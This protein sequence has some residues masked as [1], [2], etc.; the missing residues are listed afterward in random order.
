M[1]YILFLIISVL[2]I[3]LIKDIA[4]ITK[5]PA[6]LFLILIG[7]LLGSYGIY[8]FF[9]EIDK[10]NSNSS[11]LALLANYAVVIL[12]LISGIGLDL[13]NLKKIG[14]DAMVLATMPVFIEGIIMSIFALILFSIIKIDLFSFGAI[15]FFTVMFTFAMASPAIIIPITMKAKAEGKKSSILDQ[16]TM[17]GVVD[18]FAPMPF[19][20]I[21]YIISLSLAKGDVVTGLFL[22]IIEVLV[23]MVVAYFIG[24]LVGRLIGKIDKIKFLNELYSSI[25]L[26]FITLL[27]II[28]LGSFGASLGIIISFGVGIGINIALKNVNYKMKTLANTSK[29]YQMFLMPL[30]F[31]YTG[32]QI[33]V[34]KLLDIKIIILL[35]IITIAAIIVKGTVS[36]LYLKKRGYTKDEQNLSSAL[37]ASKG[38][39]LINLSLIL[40]AGYTSAGL[41]NV[42]QYM[43]ILAAVSIIISVP[44][45]LIT[46]NKII[47][48]LK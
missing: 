45:S 40:A 9:G 22:T 16:M 35:A 48:K 31:I 37:F 36:K 47:Q 30:V 15:N 23:A 28:V 29:I 3:M 8:D 17:A 38:I 7:I 5:I 25:I 6:I 42:L 39:I 21:F 18:N 12:F 20:I 32:T 43:Y 2:S 41:D 11:E 44:F 27:L 33:R 1:I 19:V 46:S 26:V 13:S 14:K 4:R 34:D 10:I 24:Y